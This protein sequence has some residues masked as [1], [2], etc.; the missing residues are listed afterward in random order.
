M[1]K[2]AASA[3]E[4]KA[5][6]GTRLADFKVP[7]LIHIVSAL[8]RNAMG[9]VQR[10]DLAAF[11]LLKNRAHNFCAAIFHARFNVNLDHKF[12]T[13]KEENL[14]HGATTAKES[15]LSTSRAYR[16]DRHA[17]SCWRGSARRC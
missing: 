15:K 14:T 2:G 10:R 16:P 3:Q 4:L 12:G 11:V 8:P 5:Y 7:K 9:K 17:R 1:L 6:C 13:I